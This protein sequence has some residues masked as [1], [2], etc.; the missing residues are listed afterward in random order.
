MGL[1]DKV[2]SEALVQ[3]HWPKVQ[4]LFQEKV[5]PAALAAA[6]DDAKMTQ[7][8]KVVY[9]ALP[10]PVKM[11]VKEEAFVTFCFGHRNELLPP[12]A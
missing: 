3:E 12:K 1:M 9:L 5:G 2:S 8:F 4:A 10:F 11:V 7:L 6:Q